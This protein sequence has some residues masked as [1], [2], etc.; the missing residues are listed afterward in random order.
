MDKKQRIHNVVNLDLRTATEVSV[1]HIAR[2]DNV[3]NLLYSPETAPLLGRMNIQNIVHPVEVPADARVHQ[4]NLVLNHDLLAGAPL[5]AVVMGALT[6]EPDLTPAEIEAG[7]Q[8]LGVCGSVRC[9]EHLIGA[10][11]AA[12]GTVLGQTYVYPRGAKLIVGS[13]TLDERFLRSLDDGSELVVTGKLNANQVL[14]NDLIGRKV[15]K[16]GISDGVLCRE[17]NAETLLPLLKRRGGHD[18]VTVIPAG[19]DLV[20]RALVLTSGLLAALPARKLYCTEIV[21]VAED[22]TAEAL[23]E[24]LEALVATQTLICPAGLQEVI[25]QK[26]DLLQTDALFYKGTLWLVDEHARLTE[27]RLGYIEGKAT[28]IVTGRLDVDPE[29]APKA[30]VDRLV[31]VHNLGRISGTADQIAA[32]E[33]LLR[34]S[35]GDMHVVSPVD[36]RKPEP[37]VD[38]DTYEITNIVNLKL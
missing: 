15:C 37:K 8:Y 23:D 7:I 31:A 20:E 32:L 9:P 16:I 35:E 18:R 25:A 22:V 2:I 17:E 34:T 5:N 28:L 6:V 1:A 21:R 10:F 14:P 11:E 26:T 33:F 4:G 12:V 29:V 24:N 36:K 19:Y 13:L 38:E 30:L 27:A 3:V